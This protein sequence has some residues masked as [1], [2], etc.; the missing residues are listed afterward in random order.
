MNDR[1]AGAHRCVLREADREA[2][3]NDI[4]FL[5]DGLGREVFFEAAIDET[6]RRGD[7]LEAMEILEHCL[8]VPENPLA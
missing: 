5:S 6:L 2:S 8:C 7:F 1:Q 4:I 3:R